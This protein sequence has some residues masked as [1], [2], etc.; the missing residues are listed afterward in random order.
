MEFTRENFLEAVGSLFTLSAQ[1]GESV[2]V[3]LVEVSEQKETARQ[4]SFSITFRV[5]ETHRAIQGLYAVR[6]ETLGEM[7][8]FLVPEG[9][10]ASGHDLVA[11]FNLLKPE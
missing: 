4:R 11:V 2:D 10:P 8:L 6:H 3:E 7:Q 9:A 1:N 5:P